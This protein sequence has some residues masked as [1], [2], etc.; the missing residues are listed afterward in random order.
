MKKKNIGL[1]AT[2]LALGVMIALPSLSLAYRED[3]AIQGPNCTLERHEAM[4]KAFENKDYE[5]WANLMG[6]RGRVTQL[7]NKDNF[8]RFAEAHKLMLEGKV[9]EAREIR[10]E[11]GLGARNGSGGGRMIGQ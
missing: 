11:L 1:G 9:S 5:A 7:V 4:T 10:Q 6:G 8:S 3:P 2:G